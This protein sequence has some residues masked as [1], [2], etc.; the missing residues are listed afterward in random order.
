MKKKKNSRK[1]NF[2]IVNPYAAGIDIGSRS[3]FVAV[4]PHLMDDNVREFGCFTSDLLAIADWLASLNITTV[5]ME[6]TGVYWIPLFEILESKG[7]EVKLVNARHVKNVPGRKKTDRLDCQWIQKL[8]SFGLL[9]GSFH[10]EG[11]IR[12]LRCYLRHRESLVKTS[13]QHIQHM[14]KSLQQMN[15][16]LHNVIF[17]IMGVTGMLIIS[18]ICEGEK[19]PKK[20]AGFRDKACKN[21]EQLPRRISST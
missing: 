18:A 16:L 14:Q 7:F 17:D 8:H 13:G 5:A 9:R 12:G 21:S 20:L 1:E 19:D 15:V 4:A 10:P 2:Q 11:K 6:S 3:H